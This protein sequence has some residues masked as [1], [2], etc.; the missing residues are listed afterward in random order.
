[1][2]REKFNVYICH[3]CGANITIKKNLSHIYKLKIA[4]DELSPCC[5]DP[6]TCDSGINKTNTIFMES[7]GDGYEVRRYV[8]SFTYE[9]KIKPV[10]DGL[11]TQTIRPLGK[12]PIE[13][14]DHIL[15]HGWEDR[16]YHSAWSWRLSIFVNH[17]EQID[18]FTDGIFF[19]E[20]GI[21]FKWND[22]DL[23]ARKD[24]IAKI[25]S[26][27]YGESMGMLFNEM[28]AKDMEREE[29]KAMEIIQ[30]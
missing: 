15:F 2:W 26:H 13:K 3:N 10:L 19:K 7:M 24:G 23:I 12:Q 16:P 14:G 1:M 18:M 20:G 8:K 29:G 9:P 27:G 22:L 6:D 17:V 28:Y 21:F 11:I 25:G 30:W 4:L 5:S